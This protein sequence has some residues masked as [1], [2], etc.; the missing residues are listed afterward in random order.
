MASSRIVELATRIS[1]NTAIVDAYLRENQLPSP[2][3]DEDG[4]VDFAIQSEEVKKAQ[5][6]AIALSFELHQLLL[7]PSHFLRP[8]VS[9]L[10][11]RRSGLTD[12]LPACLP[13]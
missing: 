7:G 1:E 6:D 8:V 2:S 11:R 10:A 13:D 9:A 12:C 4:P 5:E 3:F